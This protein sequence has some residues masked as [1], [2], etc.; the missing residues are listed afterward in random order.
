VS[1]ADAAGK[2]TWSHT[3]LVLLAYRIPARALGLLAVRLVQND[4]LLVLLNQALQGKDIAFYL[5]L[6]EHIVT[7]AGL[8]PDQKTRSDC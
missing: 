3:L 4:I 8:Q 2:H 1:P 7:A 6:I 5:M